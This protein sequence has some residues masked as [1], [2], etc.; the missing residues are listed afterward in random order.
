MIFEPNFK[1]NDN[2]W[3]YLYFISERMNIFWNRVEGKKPP[4]S[5]D[6][7]FQE[8]KFT[9]VYRI[10]DRSSQY[11]ISNVIYNGNEY[12]RED[13]FWR[14]MIY[15]HFN[16]PDTWEHITEMLGDVTAGTPLDL[17]SEAVIEFENNGGKPYSNAYMMTAAFLAGSKGKYASLK[18]N[19]WKKHQYYFYI[20]E[21]EIKNKEFM[22]RLWNSKSFKDVFD[23][24]LS[25]T[26]VA[27]FLAYQ[28]TQDLMYS[29]LFN[30]DMNTFCAA[31][32]GTIRGVERCFEIEG[33]PD[34]GQIVI[35]V[36]KN[37]KEL[38]EI[39]NESVGVELNFRP[40]PNFM[41][42]VP[43]CSNG[44]CETDKLLRGLGVATEGKEVHGKRIK[45][46]FTESS[47]RIEY[48]FPPKWSVNL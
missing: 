16:L 4:Y 43:D 45:N 3:Y 29:N 41:P 15:K 24:M 40:L 5:K 18:E 46:F 34:Y 21:R 35:W 11:L 25:I 38:F 27:D 22:D 47:S 32:P 1:P 6:A 23:L 28:Y 17:I 31:G 8:Y 2:F 30:F 42:Q 13:M 10:L 20:F 14:I 44:F 39:Y 12:S 37:L 7:I 36:Q 19:K 33:T 9:N 26:G 48:K